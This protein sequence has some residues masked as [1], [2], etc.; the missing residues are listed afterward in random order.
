MRARLLDWLACPACKGRFTLTMFEER[1]AE[2]FEGL[3]ACECGRRYP[4][5]E[6]IPRVLD[7]AFELFP[8]FVR[9]HGEALSEA[10][11]TTDARGSVP[12]PIRRTRESFGYQWTEFSAMVID[13]KRNFL[14]YIYPVDASFFPGKLGLDAGCGFGRHIYNAATFGADM[15]GVDIS[16]A[17]ESTRANTQHLPNVHL[18][19]ANLYALPFRQGIFDFAYCIGVLHH[20]PDPEAGFRALVS[21]VKPQGA[22][23]IWVYS[24]ARPVLNAMLEGARSIT[25]RLPPH[26]QKAVAWIGAAID[27]GVFIWPYRR[28]LSFPGVGPLVERVGPQRLRV[29]SRYPF[30]V[31]WADWFDRLAAPIRFYY[32]DRDLGGW[33]DRANLLRTTISPTGL[34]GWRAYGE[35]PSTGQ[36]T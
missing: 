20:L 22:V 29:Y 30:Q 35:R 18:V 27:W 19:Q 17:I 13:F 26:I 15:I 12:E 11:R 7:D 9:R 10:A 36:R 3:L 34:F 31:V 2:V 6:T 14:H 21:V 33:L 5:V 23:F 24:K 1:D 32:D 25:T 16:E 4:V 28:L 8:N